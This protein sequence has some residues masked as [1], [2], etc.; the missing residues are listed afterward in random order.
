MQQKKRRKPTKGKRPQE[1]S[2]LSSKSEAAERQE[3]ERIRQ[4]SPLERLGDTDEELSPMPARPTLVNFFERRFALVRNH[5]LQSA[6]RALESGA[7]E[8]AVLACLIHDTGLILRRPD[9]GFWA[10]ALYRPYVSDKIAFAVRYHQSL[11]FF[12]A[13]DYGY[14]YPELYKELFGRTTCRNLISKPN[15]STSGIIVGTISRC[16]SS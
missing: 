12:P 11:R 3:E 13:P 16:R 8:E 6:R 10:E 14:E 15:T 7:P 9:H 5:C 4:L 1:R 2:R